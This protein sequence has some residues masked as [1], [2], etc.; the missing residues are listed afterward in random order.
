MRNKHI[1]WFGLFASFLLLLAACDKDAIVPKYK[2]FADNYLQ[3]R[4]GT[5]WT[6]QVDSVYA[7]TDLKPIT[8]VYYINETIVDSVRDGRD[9]ILS[10]EVTSSEELYGDYVWHGSYTLTLSDNRIAHNGTDYS[11]IALSTPLIEKH[12]WLNLYESSY[13]KTSEILSVEDLQIINGKEYEKVVTVS[14]FF[15]FQFDHRRSHFS[16]FAKEVGVVEETHYK[17]YYNRLAGI[18]TSNTVTKSLLTYAY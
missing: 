6:Y 10:V 7:V 16:R 17:A 13:D 4:L 14:H 15:E 18:T 2:G 5:S 9:I 1:I 12:S 11:A 8:S 3:I